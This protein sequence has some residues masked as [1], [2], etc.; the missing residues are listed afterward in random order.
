MSSTKKEF[1]KWR[2]KEGFIV[3]VKIRKEWEN[4]ILEVIAEGMVKV[5]FWDSIRKKKWVIVGVYNSGKWEDMQGK[6]EDLGQENREDIVIIAGDFNLRTGNLGGIVDEN[7]EWKME[8]VS[9]DCK[10]SNGGRALIDWMV[11]NNLCLLNGGG[12]GWDRKSEF[13]YMREF[14]N[15][16]IFIV[17]ACLVIA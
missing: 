9:K 10:I 7:Y 14:S 17:F 16:F 13:T 15:V 11:N 3:G 1:G 2:A 12:E 6:I 4:V 5:N 8:T